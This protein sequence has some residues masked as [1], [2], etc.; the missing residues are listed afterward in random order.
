MKKRI[1]WA[2]P[3]SPEKPSS[4]KTIFYNPEGSYPSKPVTPPVPVKL[5]DPVSGISHLSKEAMADYICTLGPWGWFCL[6]TFRWNPLE[7]TAHHHFMRWIRGINEELY[8]R[9]FREKKLGVTF[10][11]A[12]ERQQNG[13]IHYHVL[14]SEEVKRLRRLSYKDYWE[15][16]FPKKK[17]ISPGRFEISTDGGN[18]YARIRQ[19]DAGKAGFAEKYLVKY[20]TKERDIFVYRPLCHPDTKKSSK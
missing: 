11:R 19:Y 14:I 10:V 2:S 16:G 13:R 5:T 17:M 8:G 4:C 15:Y 12:T 1:S 20:M 7:K 3:G 9:Y 6:L 18:G